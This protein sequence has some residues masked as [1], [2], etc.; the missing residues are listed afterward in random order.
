MTPAVVEGLFAADFDHLQR[1]Y[2]RLNTDGEPPVGSTCPSCCSRSRSTSPKS[3]TG[4]WGNEAAVSD[5]LFSEA[6]ELAY[7]FHWPLDTILDL[8]HPDRRRFLELAQAFEWARMDG[9]G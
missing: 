8:E 9:G 6:A 3:R 4:A 5:I 1:L 7:H 2:E